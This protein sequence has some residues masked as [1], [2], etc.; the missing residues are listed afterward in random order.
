MLSRRKYYRSW[1]I[2]CGQQAQAGCSGRLYCPLD[3]L[4]LAL[5]IRFWTCFIGRNWIFQDASVGLMIDL[6]LDRFFMWADR[7]RWLSGTASR[8]MFCSRSHRVF[9]AS[10]LWS[11]VISGRVAHNLDNTNPVKR[12][13]SPSHVLLEFRPGFKIGFCRRAIGEDNHWPLLK[14]LILSGSLWSDS[15]QFM[16]AV[17]LTRGTKSRSS[18]PSSLLKW[19]T[20]FRWLLDRRNITW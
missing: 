19:P 1:R 7:L 10:N 16:P 15:Y 20:F 18:D 13:V 5:R 14:A 9:K 4:L 12:I 11:A 3:R 6:L 2:S 17:T 8:L